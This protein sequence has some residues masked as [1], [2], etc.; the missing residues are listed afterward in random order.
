MRRVNWSARSWLAWSGIGAAN[1]PAVKVNGSRT[2][3]PSAL[4]V[5]LSRSPFR[6]AASI[7]ARMDCLATAFTLLRVASI[8]KGD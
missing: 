4:R 7:M 3:E 5:Y 6:L 1:S 2:S 8:G